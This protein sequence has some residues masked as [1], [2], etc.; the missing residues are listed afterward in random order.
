M[1]RC[2]VMSTGGKPDPETFLCAAKK[3]NTIPERCIVLGNSNISVEATHDAFMECV[4]VAG[5]HPIYKLG[6]ADL[7][8]PQG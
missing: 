1:R 2:K 8:I 7:V 5:K 6:A 3:L 4:A